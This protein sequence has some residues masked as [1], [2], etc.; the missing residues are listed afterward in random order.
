M[1]HKTAHK[2]IHINNRC[3]SE[4]SESKDPSSA[5]LEHFPNPSLQNQSTTELFS[6]YDNNNTV[7]VFLMRRIP[8]WL[9]MCEAQPVWRVK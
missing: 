5:P 1:M 3:R 7:N 6:F 9:Y 2:L 4:T 8:L